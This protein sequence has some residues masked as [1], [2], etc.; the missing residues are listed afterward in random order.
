MKYRFSLAT[1]ILSTLLIVLLPAI[2]G[3]EEPPTPRPTPA[4]EVQIAGAVAAA[5]TDQ[6]EDATV[7]GFGEGADLVT[8]REGTGDLI[9]LADNPSDD[10]FHSACYHKGMEPFMARGRALKAEGV[11]SSDRHRIRHEEIDA[12]KLKMAEGATSIFTVSGTGF[13]AE[14]GEVEGAKRMFV[15]YLPNA[16]A[17]STGLPTGPDPKHPSMP[18]IM[19]M[20][21]PSA[22]LMITPD[23]GDGE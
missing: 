6:S 11:K 19:R 9:C 14:S 20:G 3:G 22:H 2:V 15:V 16:T 4:P 10:R 18:W 1:S 8:L 13:N 12:G 23:M 17:E 5:P 21:T 7:L